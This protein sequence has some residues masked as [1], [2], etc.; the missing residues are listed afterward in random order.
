M[1][2]FTE[3]K[4]RNVLKLVLAYMA[5]GWLLISIGDILMP[6]LDAPDWLFRALLLVVAIGLP[7]VA[8]LAWVFELTPEGLK[9]EKDV[10][11]SES[12][13]TQTG[14]KL[15]YIVIAMLAAALSVSVY[16][17]FSFEHAAEIAENNVVDRRSIAV[18]PFTS[19]STD[20]ENALFADGIHDDLLTNLTHIAAL[21]VISRTSVM[22]YRDTTKNLGQIADELGVATVL[23]GAVQRAGNM[24]RINVQL[25]DAATDEHLWANR[26]DRELTTKN[27]FEIQSEISKHISLALKA[28]LTPIEQSRIETIPTENLEAYNLYRLG[29]HNLEERRLATTELAR[30]QFEQAVELDSGYS[31][32]YSGLADSILLLRINH[33]AIPVEVAYPLAQQAL[34]QAL[35]LDPD[36]A[37]AYASLGL[38]KL[39][40]WSQTRSGPEIEEAERAFQKAIKLNPNHARAVMWYASLKGSQQK[41]DESIE[42]YQRSL[43]LDPLGRIPYANMPGLYAAMGRNQKALDKWLDAVRLHPNWPTP[44]QNIANHLQGLG[45]IDEAIAWSVKANELDTDPLGGG[46]AIVSYLALGDNEKSIELVDAIPEDHP[47][48]DLA[49][50]FR[51]TIDGDFAAAIEAM[52]SLVV[53][54]GNPPAFV[55]DLISDVALVIDDLD[56]ARKFALMQQPTLADDPVGNIDL[57]NAHNVIKLAYI[58]QRGGD[59]TYAEKL[60]RASLEVAEKRPRLGAAG[61]GLMDVQILALLN[62]PDEAL[63]RLREAIDAGLRSQTVFDNWTLETDPYLTSIRD[64]VEFQAMIE[65]LNMY[66]SEMRQRTRRAETTGDWEQLR[67]LAQTQP[68]NPAAIS[69]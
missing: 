50:I 20:P 49:S 9:L 56:T 26:Y 63:V 55:M 34:E 29:R 68:V 36:S 57:F 4:R 39:D 54:G 52:E 23:E 8:I 18:L 59:E 67:L 6:L 14:R 62:R 2:F 32:A 51:L 66:M 45:R 19:R 44:Y 64:N 10:D 11:R 31:E 33:A 27:I 15:N 40:I 12:I 65:E 42:L 21:K 69:N 48:Y 61:H 30:T 22:N 13:T 35:A 25:I 1:S 5:V 38:L 43:E 3:L 16:L 41:F 47:I 7:T 60:L 17:N 58:A 28:A 53:E 46:V 24:V 37:D